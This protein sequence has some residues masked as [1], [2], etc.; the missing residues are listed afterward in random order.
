[1][2]S[3][4]QEEA[5][6]LENTLL[7]LQPVAETDDKWVWILDKSTGYKVNTAYQSLLTK[8]A[9]TRPEEQESKLLKRLWGTAVPSK[10]LVL[11]WRILLDRLP[12]RVALQQRG[13]MEFAQGPSCV[14]CF[15]AEEDVQHLFFLCEKSRLIWQCICQWFGA[16]LSLFAG[17]WENFQT[18]A[19]A[20]EGK[21]A[22]KTKHMV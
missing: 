8:T 10:F 11:A 21:K 14:M 15:Q 1:M 7:P 6:L 16:E 5:A 12:A 9:D 3:G 4:G 20:V 22:K 13:V 2:R 18:V 19:A 17:R